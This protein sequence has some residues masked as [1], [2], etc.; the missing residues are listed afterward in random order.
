MVGKKECVERECKGR[1]KWW[2]VV[3]KYLIIVSLSGRVVW[4]FNTV[5]I[6]NQNALFKN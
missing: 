6:K 1:K 3:I 5:Q 4:I 2:N